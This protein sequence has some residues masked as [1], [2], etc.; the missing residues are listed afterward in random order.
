MKKFFIIII[1]I[2]AIGCLTYKIMPKGKNDEN[3]EL[4]ELT[5]K[6]ALYFKNT[7]TNELEKEYR[8][9]SM[10]RIKENMFQTIIEEV[11]KGTT[12]AP[13]VSTIPNGTS[14][15]SANVEGNIA[16]VNLSEEFIENQNG[17]AKDCLFAIYSIVNS[18]TE[19]TEIEQ[20]K[21]FV[22][23]KEED[24]YLGYFSLN[25]PFIRSI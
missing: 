12:V 15:I 20:V 8:N 6:I 5:G 2:L 1:I 24:S 16:N 3:Q 7:E 13:L 22:E 11:L 14:L 25:K 21:F 4:E 18:L 9:V 23:G 17:N 19:I 10:S